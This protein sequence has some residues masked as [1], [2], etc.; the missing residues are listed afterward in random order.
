MP[1]SQARVLTHLP[2]LRLSEPSAPF[3]SGV[4]RRVPFEEFDD[5]TLGA[6]T[7]ERRA[8]ESTAPV[9]YDRTPEPE[10]SVTAYATV[11]ALLLASPGR[12]LPRADL[13]LEILLD[14]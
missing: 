11:A 13:S 1:A 3:A 2:L 7:D 4:L 10:R 14:D 6:F 12:T 9:F 5:H 8:Y